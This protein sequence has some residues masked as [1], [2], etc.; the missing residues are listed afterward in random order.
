MGEVGEGEVQH[1]EQ[2]LGGEAPAGLVGADPPVGVGLEGQAAGDGGEIEG[3]GD[4]AVV[5]RGDAAPSGL[6]RLSLVA[7]AELAVEELVVGFGVAVEAREGVE[8]LA[9]DVDDAEELGAVGF[10]EG[11]EGEALRAEEAG[12]EELD[13]ARL[14][15]VGGGKRGVR[16]EEDGENSGRAE[17]RSWGY[18]IGIRIG[19]ISGSSVRTDALC[20]LRRSTEP[21]TDKHPFLSHGEAK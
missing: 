6:V 15:A 16:A 21:F 20:T 19:L 14:G 17:S 3:A 8:V 13:R 18:R 5:E 4:A 1:R 2:A 12:G 7:E 9:A 11:A 10:A